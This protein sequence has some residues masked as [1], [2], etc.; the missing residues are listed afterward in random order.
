MWN[1]PPH[2][3][4]NEEASLSLSLS[5]SLYLYLSIYLPLFSDLFSCSSDLCILRSQWEVVLDL[6]DGGGGEKMRRGREWWWWWRGR[7]FGRI[8]RWSRERK[9]SVTV[10]HRGRQLRGRWERR[11]RQGRQWLDLWTITVTVGRKWR[12]R[13]GSVD[14]WVLKCERQKRATCCISVWR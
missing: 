6:S 9:R 1:S 8:R 12:E 14:W 11:R 13:R 2:Y 3:Q 7:R 5:L 4:R 10:E